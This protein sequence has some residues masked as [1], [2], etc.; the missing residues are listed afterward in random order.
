MR[1]LSGDCCLYVSNRRTIVMCI[2]ERVL[3]RFPQQRTPPAER[4][5]GDAYLTR[6]N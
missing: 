6:R 1:A 4:P 5:A 2:A 3:Y